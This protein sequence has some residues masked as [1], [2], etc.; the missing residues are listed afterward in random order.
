MSKAKNTV[1]FKGTAEQKKQ[2]D[3]VLAELKEVPGALMPALQ[4]AQGIYGYLPIEVQQMVA[5]GLSIPLEKVFEVATF[6]P[7]SRS[8]QRV[9]TKSRSVWEPP[10]MSRVPATYTAASKSVLGS[11]TASARRTE[12]SRSRPA[13]ASAPAALR[14]F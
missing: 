12:S 4:K 2:L 3:A 8:T 5:D 9:D 11:R 1:P 13:A 14:R 10:A 6:T 7:S